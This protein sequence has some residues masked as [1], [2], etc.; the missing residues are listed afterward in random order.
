MHALFY[1]CHLVK[2]LYVN[3]LDGWTMP[4][5]AKALRNMRECVYIERWSMHALFYK[6]HLVKFL[7]VD[8]Y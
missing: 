4:S 5:S 3:I 8:K 1:K 2:Y 7:H 6:C